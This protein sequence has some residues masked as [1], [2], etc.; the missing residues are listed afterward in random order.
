MSTKDVTLSRSEA[1]RSA[2]ANSHL[3]SASNAK[4]HSV[5]GVT[6]GSH[7]IGA[8]TLPALSV[9]HFRD[10]SGCSYSLSPGASVVKVLVEGCT[11]FNLALDGSVTTAV[12]EVWN[13]R[14]CHITI[15]CT[16]GTV[17]ADLS[18]GLHLVYREARH[19]GSIVQAGVHDLHVAFS[20]ASHAPVHSGIEQLRLQHP[21]VEIND[22]TDQFISRIV[23]GQLLTE[24]I[25]RLANEFPTTAREK[26][27][28]EEETRRKAA[29]LQSMVADMMGTSLTDEEKQELLRKSGSVQPPDSEAEGPQARAAH[30]KKLGNEAF[31]AGDH[32]QA[33]VH[34][35][36]SIVVYD[37]D[38]VVYSNRAACFLKLGRHQQALDDACKAIA[39]DAAMVKAHFRKGT[40][41]YALGRYEESAQTMAHVLKLDAS[42]KDAEAG[43]RLAQ[44]K[45]RARE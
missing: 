6:G 23:S 39:L 18:S 27:Q 12:L 30:R 8:D 2:R 29:A 40:A 28:F 43:L 3:E 5:A 7:E 24:Q 21:A 19:F 45:L 17:Q 22:T 13:C 14:D 44:V 31:K 11:G 38:P 26:A 15:G 35:T 9:L 36:E 42:N 41:L 37:S 25:V 4:V 10:C 16:I 34:Y 20:D 33:A 1:L 32:T